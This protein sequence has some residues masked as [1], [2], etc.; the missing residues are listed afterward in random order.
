MTDGQV[1]LLILFTCAWGLLGRPMV[2]KYKSIPKW[3]DISITVIVV[4]FTMYAVYDT[5]IK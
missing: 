2:L 5:F 3:L 1:A 4:I